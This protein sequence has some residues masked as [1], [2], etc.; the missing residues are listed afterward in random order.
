MWALIIDQFFPLLA[1]FWWDWEGERKR[2]SLVFE[3]CN[4]IGPLF[5]SV[6]LSVSPL[7]PPSPSFLYCKAEWKF[8][9]EVAS[10]INAKLKFIGYTVNINLNGI[11]MPG[12]ESN[13]TAKVADAAARWAGKPGRQSETLAFAILIASFTGRQGKRAIQT[14]KNFPSLAL[15]TN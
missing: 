14:Q 10:I 12:E 8:N 11:L 15:P 3:K 4:I 6:C 13:W 1:L 9:K 5:M 2:K 7:L